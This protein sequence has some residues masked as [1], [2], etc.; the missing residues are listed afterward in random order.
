MKVNSSAGF[1]QYQ[2]YLQT[3][4]SAETGAAKTQGEVRVPISDTANTDKVTFSEQ[5]L[6][7]AGLSRMATA[8]S[9]EVAEPDAARME[10]LKAAVQDGSYAVNSGAVADAILGKDR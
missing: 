4:K 8:M 10:D 3:L 9:A 6:E 7:R 1:D 5:A 2:A